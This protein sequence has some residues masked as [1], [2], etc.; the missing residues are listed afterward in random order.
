MGQRMVVVRARRGGVRRRRWRTGM[1][2]SG[3]A[4]VR[5]PTRHGVLEGDR[6]NEEWIIK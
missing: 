3:G 2:D 5:R 1:E 4:N 6:R